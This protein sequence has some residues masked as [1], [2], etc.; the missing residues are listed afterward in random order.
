MRTDSV[1]LREQR[2]ARMSW[3]TELLAA[4][5]LGGGDAVYEIILLAAGLRADGEGIE[6]A[7]A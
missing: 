7:G 4:P 2:R 1:E 5:P 6:H 3:L